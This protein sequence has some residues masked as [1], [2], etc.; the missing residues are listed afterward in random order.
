MRAA[1][2]DA[3]GDESSQALFAMADDAGR[4]AALWLRELIHS[5]LDLEERVRVGWKALTYHHPDAG[6]VAGIFPRTG[7]AELVIEHGA[8]LDGFAELFDAV[9]HQVGKILVSAVP[10]DR[11][12][13]LVD[14]IL[15]EIA[16]RAVG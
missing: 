14:L 6:Y 16:L 10:D 11:A 9:G 4:A 13:S 5:H 8:S 3:L 2:P 15:A 12:N 1:R 7:H